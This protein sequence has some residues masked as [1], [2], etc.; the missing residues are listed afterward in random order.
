VVA[1]WLAIAVLALAGCA[2]PNPERARLAD[3]DSAAPAPR[4]ATTASASSREPAPS[5][6]AGPTASA[7]P[8]VSYPDDTIPAP[9]AKS[10]ARVDKAVLQE[11]LMD[12]ARHA[13]SLRSRPSQ[14]GTL[15]PSLKADS[16]LAKVGLK[17]GDLLKDINGF[18]MTEPDEAVDAYAKLKGAKRFDIHIVRDGKPMTLVLEAK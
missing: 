8:D 10:S 12:Y 4:T 11:V 2:D 15:L 6:T 14:D 9:S 3:S 13:G 18:K 7:A 17:E 1:R 16:A 5:A